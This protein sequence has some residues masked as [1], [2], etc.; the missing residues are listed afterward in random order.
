MKA[1]VL[2]DIVN[3]L[4]YRIRPYEVETGSTDTALEHCKKYIYAALSQN[5]R[6]VPALIRC[7]R[8][9]QTV[10]ADRTRLKPKVSII[11]EFWEMTT[12]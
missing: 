4:A 8:E 1:I 10:R 7:R 9:L 11:G 5:K 6:L 2:G 12:E 3:I